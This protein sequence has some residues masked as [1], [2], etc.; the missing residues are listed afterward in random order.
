MPAL[1][2]NHLPQ[3]VQVKLRGTEQPPIIN[4][5]ETYEKIRAIKKPKS[6]IQNDL[7]KKLVQ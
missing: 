5:N 6:G 4:E 7:P 3:R 1:E 2:I